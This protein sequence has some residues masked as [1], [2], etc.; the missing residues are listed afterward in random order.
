MNKGFFLWGEGGD[1]AFSASVSR[2]LPHDF[3]M[4]V[5]ITQVGTRL[6]WVGM[7]SA[8]IILASRAATAHSPTLFLVQ[9]QLRY[10]KCRFC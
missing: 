1:G 7:K 3:P 8:L 9:S 4:L 5:L 6:N 10:C 2:Q